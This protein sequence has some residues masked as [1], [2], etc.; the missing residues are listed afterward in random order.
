MKD[1]LWLKIDSWELPPARDLGVG[2][3][4][5][6]H[7]GRKTVNLPGE[8]SRSRKRAWFS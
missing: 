2:V 7:E 4:K 3:K 6:K 1:E 5:S 8:I